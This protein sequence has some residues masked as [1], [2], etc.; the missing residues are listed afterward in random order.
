MNA[1]SA[2]AGPENPSSPTRTL[3]LGGLTIRLIGSGAS[4]PLIEPISQ[5]FL[6]DS[7][8]TPT[9]TLEV[10]E[11][12]PAEFEKLASQKPF[13][14]SGG[15]W[16]LYR[17]DKTLVY[18][19]TV[20]IFGDIPYRF[21]EVAND[22]STGRLLINPKAGVPEHCLFPL[23]FPLDELL[24]A[25]LLTLPGNEGVLLHA[26]AV[27]DPDGNAYVFVGQSGDGKSTT[28]RIWAA[29]EG[30]TILTDERVIIRRHE[31]GFFVHGTPWHGDQLA[32]VPGRARISGI[33]IL[34][35]AP[36]NSVTETRPS[37]ASALLF[38][39]SFPP[40]HNPESLAATAAFLESLVTNV[41][42]RELHFLPDSSVVDFVRG[43]YAA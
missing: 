40:L 3:C 30:M 4:A 28:A 16:K 2:L 25:N 12:D 33:F 15:T 27:T 20:P 9:I 32:A 18:A 5:R 35:K 38:A 19:V 21:L 34:R 41:P 11:G 37:L 6:V 17:E 31:D 26:C 23:A 14:D 29:R 7:E 36:A 43:L 13:F 39:R 10:G 24:V 8:V 1:A 22:F 42:C